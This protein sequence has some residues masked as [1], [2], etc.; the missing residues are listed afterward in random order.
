MIIFGYGKLGSSIAK[1]L[2]E[3]A[4]KKIF[5]ITK[6]D[7]STLKN[8][9]ES[10]EKA[11]DISLDIDPKTSVYFIC[12]GEEKIAG[13]ILRTLEKIK[14]AKIKVIY[15][16]RD[17]DFLSEE[18]QKQQGAI[19]KILQNYARSGL[20]EEMCLVEERNFKSLFMPE[21][22]LLEYNKVLSETLAKMI[23][24]VNWLQN[25]E[26]L[27]SEIEPPNEACRIKSM[28]VFAEAEERLVFPLDNV[29]QKDVYFACSKKTL[30]TDTELLEKIKETLKRMKEENV[31]VEHKI[32]TTGYEQ[33]FVYLFYHTNFIQ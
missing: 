31:K 28:G 26:P 8:V 20:F 6:S 16:L 14:E 10:E 4:N 32:V 23:N 30:E 29:R 15:I 11:P 5:C 1:N 19:S 21:V 24:M 25:E 13:G 18:V 17:E 2:A 27:S 3:L 12:S 9:E 22:S 7:F 33:D